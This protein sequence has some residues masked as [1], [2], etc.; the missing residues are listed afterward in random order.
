MN[1]LRMGLIVLVLFGAWPVL[2]QEM[3]ADTMQALKDK[4]K[5]DKKLVVSANMGLTDAEGK[6]FWPIYE[7]YQKDLEGINQ[8][9]AKVIMSY[10]DAYRTDTLTDATAKTLLDE[11]ISVDISEADLKK[12]YLPKLSKVLPSKKVARYYQI[13]NKIRAIVRYDLAGQIPLVK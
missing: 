11:A 4:V 3:S 1:L 12:T 9:L 2:A 8:R 6:G 10:A 13:E 5:A 7:S